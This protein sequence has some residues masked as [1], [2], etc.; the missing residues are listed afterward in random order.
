MKTYT[1][2]IADGNR[3][4]IGTGQ[5]RF[6]YDSWW[7]CAVMAARRA[8]RGTGRSILRSLCTYAAVHGICVVRLGTNY[9]NT[10][11]LMCA[12]HTG[13]KLDGCDKNGYVLSKVLIP[14]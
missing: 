6:Q 14:T 9:N 8:P 2:H 10:P 12:L 7:I 4:P 11:M 3:V 13:F 1:I 5:L